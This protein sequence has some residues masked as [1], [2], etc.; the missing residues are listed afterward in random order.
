MT[1][2]QP[3][4]MTIPGS[5]QLIEILTSESEWLWQIRQGSHQASKLVSIARST[6]ILGHDLASTI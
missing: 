6:S 4:I 1:D 2:I 3:E 5:V